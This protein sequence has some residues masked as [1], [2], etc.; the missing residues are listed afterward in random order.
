MKKSVATWFYATLFLFIFSQPI[1]VLASGPLFR[2][3]AGDGSSGNV[4][5]VGI[6]PIKGWRAVD[7]INRDPLSLAQWVPKNPK[8]TTGTSTRISLYAVDV[9]NLGPHRLI[10]KWLPDAGRFQVM[11]PEAGF[12]IIRAIEKTGS[13]YSGATTQT[14][15]AYPF[16]DQYI[17]PLAGWIGGVNILFVAESTVAEIEDLERD[18][19][20]MIQSRHV[21]ATKSINKI[22]QPFVLFGKNWNKALQ[23][24]WEEAEKMKQPLA[25]VSQAY[26]LFGE[27]GAYVPQGQ[28]LLLKAAKLGHDPSKMDL[29]RLAR[30]SLLSID[31]APEIVDAWEKDLA[32]KGSED[33]KFWAAERALMLDEVE[34]NQTTM[35]SLAICGQPEARRYWIKKQVQSFSARDRY[36]GRLA[37][38]NLMQSPP[39]EATL[40]I[41]TRVPRAVEAPAIQQLKEAAV[42]KTACPN[43]DDP[44]ESLF[45]K[46]ADFETAKSLVK[47]QQKKSD[48]IPSSEGEDLPELKGVTR[49]D[50]LANAG[51][52]TQLKEALKLACKW[53]GS[54]DD[55]RNLVVEL[56]IRRDGL[57]KWK[58]FRSCSVVKEYQ[59][60]KVCRDRDLRQA[61]LNLETRFNDILINAGMSYEAAPEAV[62]AAI[63]FRKKAVEFADRL[64]EKSYAQATTLQENRELDQIRYALENEFMSLLAAT[65]NNADAMGL[66]SQIGEIVTGR[67]LL[68]LPTEAE[69][70]NFVLR[71]QAPTKKFMK[72]EL[73]RLEARVKETMRSIEEADKIDLSNDFKSG[74]AAAHAAWT[75]YRKAHSRFVAGVSASHPQVGRHGAAAEL[76][77]HIQGIYYFEML[78]D[79]QMSRVPDSAIRAVSSESAPTVDFG[80]EQESIFSDESETQED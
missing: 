34:K 61:K 78:R 14:V 33:A 15:I 51:N 58:R 7:Q 66:D 43:E 9:G 52:Q 60:S 24:G 6:R 68:M 8:C 25:L 45:V 23:V 37:V 21:T 53:P 31:L 39:L 74:L 5:A 3:R 41:T 67:R 12:A 49:L 77:F 71:R 11:S 72:R 17:T 47:N 57:G 22:D 27:A 26:A 46:K 80:S 44:D 1:Q 38:V 28:N 79:R 56:A 2:S 20:K 73:E 30:R 40:P 59:L 65:L 36:L 70:T 63:S 35:R 13:D 19:R 55:R 48:A 18:L 50:K 69:N 76:W 16:S 75:E 10:Q 42:L 64:L 32:Q 4:Q 54:E 62:T 29:V